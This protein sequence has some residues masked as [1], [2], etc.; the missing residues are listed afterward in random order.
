VAARSDKDLV[1]RAFRKIMD[2]KELTKQ[3]SLALKRHEKE[4]EER[5]RWQYYANIPQKHWRE[6]SG[7]Q[8]KVRN[9]QAQRD[10]EAQVERLHDVA[11]GADEDLTRANA[12]DNR[13]HVGDAREPTAALPPLAARARVQRQDERLVPRSLPAEA[14]VVALAAAVTRHLHTG[15]V[16]P[17][18]SPKQNPGRH[19]A[20][21]GRRMRRTLD[22]VDHL[23]RYRGPTPDLRLL[24]QVRNWYVY[25]RRYLGL[26]AGGT[27]EAEDT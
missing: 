1:A 9:E 18:R 17:A 20:A 10:E 15:G 4:K 3:E 22:E 2:H 8:T 7:R 25:W 5:L 11:G 16:E 23:L 13:R 26:G 6:M 21:L 12:G 14:L 27:Q 19:H 24:H